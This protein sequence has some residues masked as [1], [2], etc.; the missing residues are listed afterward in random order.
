MSLS[1]LNKKIIM[2]RI[3]LATTLTLTAATPFAL[4]GADY[5]E[6]PN[7]FSLGPRFGLNFKAD[8]GNSAT[9]FN[10]V[11]PGPE[12]GG[13]NHLYDDGYVFVDYSGNLDGIT[14]YWGY[15]YAPQVAGDTMQ[16]H[17]I[18]SSGNTSRADNPQYGV[19]FIYQRVLGNLPASMP[20]CWGLE[21]G[22]GYTDLDLHNHRNGT[23]PVTTD[24]FPLNGV[25][26]PSAGYNGTFTGP[27]ALLGDTPTRTLGSASM[28]SN[29]KLRGSLFSLRLG[30]FA[31]WHFT[32]KF[33][34]AASAG[35]T[36]APTMLDY[37]FSE[38]VSQAGGGT[39]AA[40]GHSSKTR[41]LYG[42]FV[43]ATLRYDFNKS[44]GAYLGAQFQS[45]N[46]LKQS[47]GSRT[48]RFDP[49]ATVYLTA[50][51]NWIF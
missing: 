45:L 44:W 29:Q 38:T 21:V 28:A 46:S 10:A 36:L 5:T 17:A 48:A 24:T 4:H 18:H 26:P 11:N 39:Y 6:Y 31:E 13:A 25:L 7:R 33:S 32:P 8:F 41:L 19:E 43:G 40:S 34:L 27:G 37:D 51:V 30:P 49:G 47:V 22:F 3:L 1:T 15:Q 23:V 12:A 16:F 14:S 20:G 50:G 2:N 9:Y 35:F 42:P